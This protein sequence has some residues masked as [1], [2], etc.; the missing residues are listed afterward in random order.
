MRDGL[1]AVRQQSLHETITRSRAAILAVL[2]TDEQAQGPDTRTLRS[3][4]AKTD[5]VVCI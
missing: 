3:L 5:A 1:F 4:A 2:T